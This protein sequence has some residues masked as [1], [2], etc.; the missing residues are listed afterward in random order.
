MS[1]LFFGMAGALV[2]LSFGASLAMAGGDE[3]IT[4]RKACMKANGAG[5]G[6][7]VAMVKGEKPYDAAAVKTALDTMGKACSAW[8]TFWPPD[9]M[10]STTQKTRATDAIWKNPAGFAAAGEAAYKAET[11]LAATTDEAGFKAA[12]P[13]VGAA[14]GGCHKAFRAAQE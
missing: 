13:A 2:A 12:F 4:A 7:M 3:S 14:C 1:K 6:V 11:A 5:L 10:T 8:D 9:S